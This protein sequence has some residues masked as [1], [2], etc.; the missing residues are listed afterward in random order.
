MN[1][2]IAATDSTMKAIRGTYVSRIFRGAG[3][4]FLR[5]QEQPANAE[6]AKQAWPETVAWFKKYLK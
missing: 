4:G 1:A 6:A 3:H 5:A 2:T